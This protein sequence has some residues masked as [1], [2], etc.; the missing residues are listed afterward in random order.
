MTI[1]QKYLE[2]LERESA[3]TR[4]ILQ[5]VPLDKSDWKPHPKSMSL[6]R[7][8]THVAEIPSWFK[9]T[10][11]DDELDFQKSDYKPYVARDTADLL[12]ILEKPGSR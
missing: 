12:G 2:E 5:A 4:N 10:L 11:E 1:A 7:L 9:N 3:A 6:G 8:A